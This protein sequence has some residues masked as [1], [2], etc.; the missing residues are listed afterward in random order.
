MLA[1]AYQQEPE[2]ILWSV[3]KDGVLLSL[4]FL[5]SQEISGWARHTTAGEYRSVGVIPSTDATS[6]TL[7]AIVKRTIGGVTKRYVEYFD[8]AIAIDSVLSYDGTQTA[9]TV[10]P[11]ATTGAGVT[12]TASAATFTAGDVGKDIVLAVPL[13]VGGTTY[14]NCRAT[15]TGY[16]D[17]THVVA[18][19]VNAFPNTSAIAAGGWGLAVSTVSGLSH[20]EGEEV[21]IVGDGAVYP[22]QTVTGGSVTLSGLKALVI[23][24][25][26]AFVPYVKT[27][28]PE[29][30]KGDGDTL[31]GVKK[32]FARLFVRVLETTGVWINGVLEEPVRSVSTDVMGRAPA[33]YTG[34][35]ECTQLGFEEKAVVTI[36]QRLPLK[37]ELLGLW[38]TLEYAE[39]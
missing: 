17:A 27:V 14:T 24:A 28:E 7:W 35:V 15:I 4:T 12:F 25:G 11:G 36:E 2:T 34:D 16:T 31:L 29:V 22:E 20:L 6:D 8:P 13:T 37:S 19:I 32:R 38:G 18:T 21:A 10:T 30:T 9:A 5:P 33:P 39:Q 26:L 1:F 3:R 23:H